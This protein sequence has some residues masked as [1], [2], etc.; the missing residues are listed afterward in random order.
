MFVASY[1][2][3]KST[4]SPIIWLVSGFFVLRAPKE[5]TY[6][7]TR[8]SDWRFLNLRSSWD[9]YLITRTCMCEDN[10]RVRSNNTKKQLDETFQLAN[11]W[12]KLAMQH[13]QF[14]LSDSFW[15]R[16]AQTDDFVLNLLTKSVTYS[17]TKRTHSTSWWKL[18]FSRLHGTA[19]LVVIGH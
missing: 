4:H 6:Y 3:V 16:T 17:H 2:C 8:K 11:T 7:F 15:E 12:F 10:L 1:S 5:A 13:A 9:W 19:P 14:P 18:N